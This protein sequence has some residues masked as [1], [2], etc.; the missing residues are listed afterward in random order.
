MTVS[1]CSQEEKALSPRKRASRSKA[2]TNDLLGQ[3]LGLRL[4]AAKPPAEREDPPQVEAVKLLESPMVARLR[5]R[6]Q[7][8][9]LR[10]GEQSGDPVRVLAGG[11]PRSVASSTPLGYR[12]ERAGLNP[13]STLRVPKTK[14]P[15][16]RGRTSGEEEL[17]PAYL[18][19]A[20]P[21]RSRRL[22]PHGAR[23]RAAS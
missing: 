4:V 14:R 5:P 3:L 6:H 23:S 13:V 22:P 15:A 10:L 17:S 16:K 19:V 12:P 8:P 11:A 18:R 7:P 2:R 1:R 20:A 21:H 9:G